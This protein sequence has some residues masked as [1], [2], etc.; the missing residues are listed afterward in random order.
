MVKVKACPL[1]MFLHW[2]T[3]TR[4]LEPKINSKVAA[5][6]KPKLSSKKYKNIKP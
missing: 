2:D 1:L 5:L 6:Y 3:F 4:S